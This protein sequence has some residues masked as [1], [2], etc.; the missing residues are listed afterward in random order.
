MISLVFVRGNA[1]NRSILT[2][3]LDM[4]RR[5]TSASNETT[6]IAQVEEHLFI[7]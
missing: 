7:M 3:A 6:V 5:N 4:E 1:G 2:E